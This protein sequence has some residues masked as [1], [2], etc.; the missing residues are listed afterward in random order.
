MIYSVYDPSKHLYDYFEGPGPKG[1]HAG[2]P[3]ARRKTALGASPEAAAWPLPVAAV[4][5]GEGEMPRG[6]I[7]YATAPLAALGIDADPVHLGIAAG[8]V[9]LAW[10]ALK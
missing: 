3:K 6:R 4:K 5:I 7:A 10:R 2:S 8:L 9:Y 1:T